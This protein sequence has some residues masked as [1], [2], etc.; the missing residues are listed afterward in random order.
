M[1]E[2]IGPTYRYNSEILDRPEII[3]VNDH[4][5]DDDNHCFHVKT[6]LEHSAC[7][8]QQHFLIFNHMAHEDQLQHFNHVSLPICLVSLVKEFK[9][10]HIK[11][12]W[13]NKTAAF[14]FMINKPR[15]NREFLLL[16]IKHFGLDNYTYSL[17][18]KTT[19]L[20]RDHMIRNTVSDVYQKI[21]HDTPIDIPEKTYTFGHEVFMEHGLKSGHVNN[22]KNYVGLLQT[23]VFEPSYVSLITEPCFYERE[24]FMT[25]KTIMALYGGTLPIWIGG[26]GIPDSMRQLGFDVFD[27]IVDHGYQHLADPWDR[28]YWAIEKNLH[29]LKDTKITQEFMKNNHPR[30]QHNIDLL[31]QNVFLKYCVQK[32]SQYTGTTHNLLNTIT[33][34]YRYRRF[35]DYKLW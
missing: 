10:Q 21:I 8:P 6:L 28:A 25:E 12:N 17:C 34:G 33:Q 24:T 35:S 23:T 13:N 7:D 22:A 18:W 20:K 2:I 14:N 32:I 5:Y 31:E 19:N 11:P 4:Q 1:I 29:L 26:W 16:L 9:Q 30:L 3:L 27:D 15:H